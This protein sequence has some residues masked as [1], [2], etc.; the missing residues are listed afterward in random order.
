MAIGVPDTDK[1]NSFYEEIGFI[2]SKGSWGSEDRPGQIKLEEAPYRQLTHLKIACEDDADLAA[3]ATRLKELGVAY[4]LSNGR[5]TV[6]DPINKWQFIVEPAPVDDVSLHEKRVINFPGDR[7]RFD[8]RADIISETKPRAPRRL[9]HVVLGSPEP[10]KTVALCLALGFRV[11]D[12]IGG[13]LATFMRCSFDHHNL[14]ITPGPVP[15]LNHYALE[16]DDFDSVFKAAT[17]YIQSHGQDHSLAGPGRHQ[18]GGNIFWYMLDPSGNFFE[19]FADMDQVVNEETWVIKHDWDLA[20]SWSVWGEKQQPEIF[21]APSD[22][23]TIIDGWH[24]VNG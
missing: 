2:G 23:Q 18:I 6:V 20:D 14:L 17:T 13:G 7:K 1:L 15:Y 22:I 10:Q 24:A 12:T 8:R 9:G 5:L 3:A 21:F 11:S 16:H 4:D 19:F